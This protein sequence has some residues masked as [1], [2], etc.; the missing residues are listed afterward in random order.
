MGSRNHFTGLIWAFELFLEKTR[1]LHDK[2]IY[3]KML[4]FY[5]IYSEDYKKNKY[6]FDLSKQEILN[7][8]FGYFLKSLCI[9]DLKEEVKIP[10]KDEI[11][12][13][14]EILYQIYNDS[15]RQIEC[16][17]I[18]KTI[19]QAIAKLQAFMNFEIID[20][21]YR[22]LLNLRDDYDNDIFDFHFKFQ[23]TL[24]NTRMKLSSM[25]TVNIYLLGK[26]KHDLLKS[27]LKSRRKSY[28]YIYIYEDPSSILDKNNINILWITD[29]MYDNSSLDLSEFDKVFFAQDISIMIDSCLEDIQL[30]PLNQKLYYDLKRQVMIYRNKSVDTII[31]GSSYTRHGLLKCFSDED[32]PNLSI[33][34][35]DLYTALQFLKLYLK[36]TTKINA[37]KRCILPV[38]YWFFTKDTSLSLNALEQDLN[39]TCLYTLLNDIHNSKKEFVPDFYDY[40]STGTNYD[41]YLRHCFDVAKLENQIYYSCIPE[42]K[43]LAT[44]VITKRFSKLSRVSRVEDARKTML[45]FNKLLKYKSSINENKTI[46]ST[47]LDLLKQ[48][49]IELILILAPFSS[50]FIEE[51]DSVTT[52]LFDELIGE[53]RSNYTYIDMNKLSDIQF[54][55]NDFFDST[56][57]NFE[58]AEKFTHYINK[59]IKEN[60]F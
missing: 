8:S 41:F 40:L 14:S 24:F 48:N 50:T 22:I 53:T 12:I 38:G 60:N 46:F 15:K 26:D 11:L 16:V 6:N 27:Q 35:Q 36:N 9:P 49:N 2:D 17:D 58:G 42:S 56:H 59:I 54:N 47:F 43:D 28:I 13:L 21:F 31:L 57:L 5:N 52:S 23:E 34:G 4:E 30:R 37:I 51:L 3:F 10:D 25:L 32:F 18:A 7:C 1:S 19:I 33:N 20:S 55:D 44:S 29:E 45:Y 39:S